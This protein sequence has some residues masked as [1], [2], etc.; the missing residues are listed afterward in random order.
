M[1]STKRAPTLKSV[2]TDAVLIKFSILGWREALLSA[3]KA[4]S[5]SAQQ[6]LCLALDARGK[7]EKD[8]AREAFQ[9]AY[10]AAYVAVRPGCTGE[11]ARKTPSVM[12]RVSEAMAVFKAEKLPEPMPE[13]LSRA[14]DACR[15]LN[16][17]PKAVK[18]KPEAANEEPEDGSEGLEL[19][20]AVSANPM[21]ALFASLE[22]L[23]RQA[24]NNQPALDAL[25]SMLDL[26]NDALLA[27]LASE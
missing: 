10:A 15:K 13:N 26:A 11:Q 6:L 9:D 25:S 2:P 14:A 23:Q 18:A 4:E 12:N 5:S 16:A 19:D 1:A 7:V 20:V 8:T 24:V 22:A 21:E 17:K 27:L 3:A